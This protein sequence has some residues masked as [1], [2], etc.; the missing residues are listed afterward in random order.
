[1]ENQIVC[2]NCGKALPNNAMIN[3][4]IKGE[5]SDTQSMNCECGE[6]I[7]YWNMRAQLRDQ[8]TMGRRFRNWVRSLSHSQG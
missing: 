4:V 3:E 7:T 8:K 5:G 6:R 1:M 2:P